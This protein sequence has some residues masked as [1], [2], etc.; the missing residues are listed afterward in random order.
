M[1]D[2][3]SSMAVLGA[4]NVFEDLGFE[5]EEALNLK[6]RADLMLDL[7][8]CIQRSRWSHQET[9]TLLGE[10]QPTINNLMNGE[11]SQFSIDKL[12]E[13]L[14]KVG[15]KVNIEVVSDAA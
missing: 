3:N 7:Q 6:I 8:A 15:M 2:G 5:A 9:A 11:I 14:G 12:I 13:F 10:T 4:K 1:T